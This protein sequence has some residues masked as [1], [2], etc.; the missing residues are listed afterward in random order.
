MVNNRISNSQSGFKQTIQKSYGLYPPPIS[1]MLKN[2][3]EHPLRNYKLYQS[4]TKLY[5][6]NV[7]SNFEVYAINNLVF[8]NW[9]LEFLWNTNQITGMTCSSWEAKVKSALLTLP[10]ATNVEVTGTTAI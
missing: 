5:L 3:S 4:N 7:S 10:D 6:S 9:K 1:N 2:E 8:T